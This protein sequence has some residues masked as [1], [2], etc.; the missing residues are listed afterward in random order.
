MTHTI[1]PRSKVRSFVRPLP[2]DV[3]IHQLNKSL[4]NPRAHEALYPWADRFIMGF[5]LPSWQRTLKWDESQMI[6]FILSIWNDVDLGTYLINHLED[7]FSE[8][9]GSLKSK[10]FTDCL[11]DGQQRLYSI[12]AYVMDEIKVPDAQGVPRLYSELPVMDKR[13]FGSK[14]FNRAQVSSD[15]EIILRQIYDLR[16]FGGTPHEECERALPRPGQRG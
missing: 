5:P 12:Q 14:V 6:R 4:E 7:G 3:L 15:E 2:I 1:M 9:D 11:L 13:Y 16:A 8:V 10:V